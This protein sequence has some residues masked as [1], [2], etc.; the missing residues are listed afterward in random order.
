M[1][2]PNSPEPVEDEVKVLF[3]ECAKLLKKYQ[4]RYHNAAHAHKDWERGDALLKALAE[5]G[6]KI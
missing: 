4:A 6:I 3:F 5:K 2:E 1:I